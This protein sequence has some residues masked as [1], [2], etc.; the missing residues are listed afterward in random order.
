MKKNYPLY[1]TLLVGLLALQGTAMHAQSQA[2][3][4]TKQILT[5]GDWQN[6]G[7]DFGVDTQNIPTTIKDLFYNT[8]GNLVKTIDSKMHLGDNPTTLLKVE[9]L[10]DTTPIKYT[11]Y[12]YNDKDQL[13]SV[14]ECGYRTNNGWFFQWAE[15]DTISAFT[16]NAEGK[17]ATKKEAAIET[18]YSWEGAHLIKEQQKDISTSSVVSTHYFYK[19]VSAETNLAQKEVTVN[20]KGAYGIYYTYVDYVGLYLL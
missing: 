5:F 17:L 20:A 7:N 14:V 9:K 19:F 1:S 4:R 2:I 18:S 12:L 3:E 16:Y 13:Q 15:P 10:G 8:K 6:A 11:S